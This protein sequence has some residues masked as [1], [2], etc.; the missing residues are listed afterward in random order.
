MKAF[1][2]EEEKVPPTSV[3][4]AHGYVQH[5]EKMWRGDYCDRYHS[6]LSPENHDL[7]VALAFAYEEGSAWGTGRPWCLQKRAFKTKSVPRMEMW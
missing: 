5:A 1:V 4:V 7:P 2:I 6:Y 3:H